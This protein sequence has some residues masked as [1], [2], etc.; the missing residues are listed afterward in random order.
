MSMML[1]VV[2]CGPGGRN[3]GNGGD[4]DGSGGVDAPFGVCVPSS[5]VCGDGIDNDC[6]LRTDCGDPDCSGATLPAGGTCPVCGVVENPEST[7]LPL[8]DGIGESTVCSTDAQCTTAEL[9]NCVAKECHASYSSTLDFIGFPDGAT[10]TDTSKLLSVCVTMEHSWLRDLQIELVGPPSG[11]QMV[12]PIIALHKFIDR[13]GGEIFLGAANDSDTAES[14][15]PGT[16]AKYCWTGTATNTMLAAPTVSVGGSDTLPAGD[17][18][19]VAPFTALA[20]ASLNGQ[21]EMRVTDLWPIDNGFM[22]E[23]SI[24][25]DPSLVLDCAGPIIQ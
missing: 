10:L 8:P 12:R 6:D 23:W 19:P 18:A 11:A 7:P 15:V 17:Y 4:D 24:S 1:A 20:G 25:F 3:P 9:P 22:F 13:T 16:G 14:P 5:E 21:W 2:A